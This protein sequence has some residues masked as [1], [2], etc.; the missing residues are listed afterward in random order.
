MTD[1]GTLRTLQR[2]SRRR[3]PPRERRLVCAACIGEVKLLGGE[4]VCQK[5]GCGAKY[6]RLAELKAVEHVRVA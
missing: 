3:P 1:H 5:P 4:L 2:I 6:A